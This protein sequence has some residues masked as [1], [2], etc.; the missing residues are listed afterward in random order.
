MKNNYFFSGFTR[1][2]FCWLSMLLMGL[3]APTGLMAQTTLSAGDIAFVGFNGV[4]DGGTGNN[5]NDKFSFVLLKNVA[6]NTK[7]FFTDFGWLTGGGFQTVSPTAGVGSKDDGIISWTASTS[8]AAGTQVVILC[9]YN[10]SAS[11]G[12]V[13]GVE[14]VPAQSFYMN[15]GDPGADNIFAYQAAT[16]RDAN[17]TLLAGIR[18]AGVQTTWD[19]T[20]SNTE[21]TPA[22]TT[23]PLI[24]ASPNH[25][26][27]RLI[28]PPT[29]NT[30][31]QVLLV[32]DTFTGP[33][34]LTAHS[35]AFQPAIIYRS[36]ARLP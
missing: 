4:D 23:L 14:Q 15:I 28:I 31:T 21:F 9:K 11:T 36:T 26:G 5:S 6:A 1:H 7:I 24:M 12:T 18:T 30:Q 13:A 34:I 32:K 10:L 19:A 25:S 22:K 2:L 8:L 35:P 3:I 33:M 20:L 27:M 17:P 16:A 29:G